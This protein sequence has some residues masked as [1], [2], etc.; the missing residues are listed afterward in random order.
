MKTNQVLIRKMGDFDVLQRTSDGMF[1]ANALLRQWNSS[2]DNK[3]RRK[4]SE[5]LE[6]SSTKEFINA[7]IEDECQS[8][9][10]DHADYQAVITVK[11]RNTVNGKTPDRVWLNALIFI[12]F[13]MWLN[14]AFKVKVLKFVYDELIKYRIDAGDNYIKMTSSINKI[15]SKEYL[16]FAIRN[17]A[18]AINIIVYGSHEKEIRNKIGEADKT[19]QLYELEK[20]ITL[21]IDNNFIQDYDS[22]MNW[23][24]KLWVDKNQPQLFKTTN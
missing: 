22:L 3:R 19:R 17:V 1:D 8:R 24:R 5:Y 4:M 12:D 20:N 6:S 13:C 11:G 21:L 16:S 15:V 7:I 10:I 9:K 18:K 2:N 14:P 23:L